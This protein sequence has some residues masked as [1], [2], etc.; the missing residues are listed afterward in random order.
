MKKI[1]SLCA[2]C[3][4]LCGVGFYGNAIEP[5]AKQQS[6]LEARCMSTLEDIKSKCFCNNSLTVFVVSECLNFHE[7]GKSLDAH[8]YIIGG[9]SNKE[10]YIKKNY[11]NVSEI[12]VMSENTACDFFIHFG[13]TPFIKKFDV[14][15]V[16]CDK[17][18]CDK[19]IRKV[20]PF[21]EGNTRLRYEFL[22]TDVIM[23]NLSKLKKS[24]QIFG[25][26]NVED[27]FIIEQKFESKIWD[28]KSK[29][30]CKVPSPLRLMTSYER[31]YTEIVK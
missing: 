4:F 7:L 13:H 24:P 29:Y 8:S 27:D 17:E 2:I 20:R 3:I 28:P 25:K 21:I 5:Y 31:F 30:N 14:Y 18:I 22:K 19:T 16:S 12:L 23:Y 11:N 9:D 10:Y 1:F 26:P 6:A 15:F